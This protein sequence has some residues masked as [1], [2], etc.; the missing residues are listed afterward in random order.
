[1]RQHYRATY[2]LIGLS[3]VDT[4]PHRQLDGLVK[5]RKCDLFQFSNRFF[6]RVLLMQL[7]FLESRK[8]FLASFHFTSR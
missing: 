8:I 3:R 7:N 6:K 5:L 1:M 2:E 4:Q